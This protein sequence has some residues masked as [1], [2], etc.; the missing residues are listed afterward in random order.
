MNIHA[1]IPITVVTTVPTKEYP[2]MTIDFTDDEIDPKDAPFCMAGAGDDDEDE[3]E[4]D[5]DDAD[6]GHLLETDSA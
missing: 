2:I 5:L 1:T 6:E 4:G 3:D